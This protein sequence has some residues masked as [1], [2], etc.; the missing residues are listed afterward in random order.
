MVVTDSIYFWGSLFRDTSQKVRYGRL[1][2]KNEV[3]PGCPP[4]VP[5]MVR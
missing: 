4:L 3:H 2:S 1:A 5:Y